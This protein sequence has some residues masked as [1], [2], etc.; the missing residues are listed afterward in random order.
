MHRFLLRI[1]LNDIN[2]NKTDTLV[3]YAEYDN[4][5]KCKMEYDRYR[6]TY[7]TDEQGQPTGIRAYTVEFS[8]A[9]YHTL[10]KAE[11]DAW[12]AGIIQ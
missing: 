12:S 5:L 3:T 10:T 2:G 1:F 9:K 11:S 7:Q 8:E 6:N 4:E